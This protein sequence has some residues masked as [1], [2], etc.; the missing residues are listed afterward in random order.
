MLSRLLDKTKVHMDRHQFAYSPGR[1]VEDAVLFLLHS[2]YNHLDSP[3]SYARCLFG[4]YSSAF[5][6]IQ[7]HLMVQKLK[8][9]N[10]PSDLCLWIL[11]F[12][13]DSN[14]F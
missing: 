2:L 5:N 9:L 4:D 3:L 11:D 13:I 12:L 6:T 1:S 10:I 14:M 8:N 7:P